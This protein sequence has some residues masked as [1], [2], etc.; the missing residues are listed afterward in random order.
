MFTAFLKKRRDMESATITL[1]LSALKNRGAGRPQ[2]HLQSLFELPR[3]GRLFIF[4]F[5]SFLSAL[6]Y[7]RHKHAR[8]VAI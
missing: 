7:Y 5:L 2:G 3:N 6:R 1:I 8:S 4:N